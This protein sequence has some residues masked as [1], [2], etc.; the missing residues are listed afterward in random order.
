MTE[1]TSNNWKAKYKESAKAVAKKEQMLEQ[2][3]TLLNEAVAQLCK[4]SINNPSGS[5]KALKELQKIS[6]NG[7]SQIEISCALTALHDAAS[8]S[9]SEGG[10][11]RRFFGTKANDATEEPLLALSP[12]QLL[13]RLLNKL[14]IPELHQSTV[15]AIR[16]QLSAATSDMELIKSLDQIA[17][18][19][20]KIR[21]DL[22]AENAELS[23]FLD[24]LGKVF[25]GISE[26]VHSIDSYQTDSSK[27]QALLTSTLETE[28]ITISSSLANNTN[29]QPLLQSLIDSIATYKKEAELINGSRA[30]EVTELT[31][32][33][34]SLKKEAD[35]LRTKL[36]DYRT[37]AYQ[38][39]LT[40]IPN[41]LAYD[42]KL[43]EE[44]ARWK[45]FDHP[46]SLLVWDID[47]FKAI[48]DTYGHQEGDKILRS[49]AAMLQDNIRETDFLARYGGEEFVIILPGAQ[50]RYAKK[51]A[52]KLRK[53]IE[54]MPLIIDKKSIHVTMSCGISEFREGDSPHHVFTRADKAL[55]N[56]KEAGRNAV[57]ID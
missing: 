39:G 55:Y 36:K 16:Q 27:K 9:G 52:E 22:I 45:R 13:Q 19:I 12:H 23:Q 30:S 43:K 34:S 54:V 25:T 8:A 51:V 37:A 32:E 1:I 14:T 44:Y 26:R 11:I 24:S 10:F 7:A 2:C 48:N 33:I 42:D 6:Q 17:E 35:G 28:V 15:S 18:I 46:V 31:D 50:M 4:I 5:E 3:E 49:V 57:V 29:V 41:R 56:A 53:K 40:K 20:S 47:K 21:A 38:D